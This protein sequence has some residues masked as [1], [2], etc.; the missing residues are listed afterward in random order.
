M[1]GMTG[2]CSMQGWASNTGARPIPNTP[3]HQH[4]QQSCQS[5]N[6]LTL[7][8]TTTCLAPR[9]D[10]IPRKPLS[11]GA[12]W[13]RWAICRRGSR[14]FAPGSTDLGLSSPDQKRWMD[15]S[16]EGCTSCIAEKVKRGAGEKQQGGYRTETPRPPRQSEGHSAPGRSTPTVLGRVPKGL[17]AI[18][19]R[20]C[21]HD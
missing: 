8:I 12:G 21:S 17:T 1:E 4:P 20:C 13:C 10:H 19:G 16:R 6:Q 18:P 15:L 11:G 2:Y 9:T 14:C 5:C 3:C 7:K